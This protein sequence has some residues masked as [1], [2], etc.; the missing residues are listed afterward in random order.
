VSFVATMTAQSTL[1]DERGLTT[2]RDR[3]E[4]TV[5]S[6]TGFTE[7]CKSAVI[8]HH[9]HHPRISSRRKSWNKTSGPL[10]VTYYTTAV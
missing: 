3:T 4:A 8:N 6:S 7:R 2:Q 1:D 9:H 10:F 5:G